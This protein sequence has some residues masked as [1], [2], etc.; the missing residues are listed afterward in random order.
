MSEGA[1]TPCEK[2]TIAE[3]P[4]AER[5]PALGG[6][7]VFSASGELAQIV[8]GEPFCFLAYIEFA[9]GP[10]V[11]RGN[12]FHERRTEYLYIVRGTLVAKYFDL[13]T[14]EE[15]ELLLATGNMVEV[16]PRCAHSYAAR[17]YSQAL[18]LST[19][20]YDPADSQ[21]FAFSSG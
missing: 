6:A 16:L 12:H 3:L 10:G 7:R 11:S 13:D 5:R 14:R 9:G 1:E 19:G 21:R 8:N 17:E 15:M 20:L 18:E 2:V 4:L